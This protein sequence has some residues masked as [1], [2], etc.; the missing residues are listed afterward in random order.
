MFQA[1]SPIGI[2][3]SGMGGL[4]VAKAVTQQLPSESIVYF[5]DTAHAPWGD[6]SVAAIQAY[7][8]K[9][10]DILLHQHCKLILIACN[11]ASAV[12]YD[13]V[14]EY[15]GHRVTVIDVVNPMVDYLA[16][17]YSKKRVGLIGTQQ[18]VGSDIYGK[19]IQ[20]RGIAMRFNALATPLLV[21]LI[22]SGERNPKVIEEVIKSYLL[23]PQ[24]QNIDAL[25][26]GCT[27]YPLIKDQINAFY[28]GQTAVIDATEMVA[29]EVKSQLQAQE[30]LA[31]AEQLPQKT[32]YSSDYT[33]AFS[34]LA[35]RFFDEPVRLERYALWD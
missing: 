32:F 16:T 22:E 1:S 31:P 4:T 2:F 30:L 10:C 25:V 5:G 33:Q 7:A 17:H 35:R 20:Q 15:V 9:I 13:L 23:S 24:L 21:P 8:V 14:K 26:L 3:D 6:K 12:A 19:K 28:S 18:T 27:H 34:A 29:K 11:S